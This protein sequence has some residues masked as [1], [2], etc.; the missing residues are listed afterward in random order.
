MRRRRGDQREQGRAVDR[1]R[2]RPAAAPV[3]QPRR[4]ER[5]CCSTTA[6]TSAGCSPR[7]PA[8]TRC[9]SPRRCSP[10]SCTRCSP[11][12][13]RS[14]SAPAGR[15]SPGPRAPRRSAPGTPADTI[16]ECREAC[17]GRRLPLGEPLRRAARRHRRVHHLRG[18]QPHPAAA[19]RQGP[20]HRLL[21]VLRGAR[22]A[23]HGA[24]R[25]R[26][27]RRDRDRAHRRAQAARADQGRAARQR[28]RLGPGG[29]AARPGVPARDAA[30]AR[31]AH[32][33]RRRPSAQA[34]DGRRDGSRRGVQ[35]VPGPRHRQ[36][37][38]ARRAAGPRGVRRPG[39]GDAGR[40]QQ[41]GAEPALR[42]LR[43]STIEAGRAWWMEHG[44]LSSA[45]SK[46]ISREVEELCR[47]VRPL[48]E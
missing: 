30:L 18:R 27:R 9:T 36:R 13:R 4:A 16:Q 17:G 45:R 29:R 10:G 34:R 37:P 6:C 25:R 47:K 2:V 39:R 42:P 14:T 3:R 8:P 46:A 1:G 26:P 21:L 31:G 28:R 48:A 15:W 22:P 41:G 44:R 23:R 12:P 32:A 40:G 5:S 20:A 19:G 11:R 43:T 38:R 33:R 24:V 7:W 35:P